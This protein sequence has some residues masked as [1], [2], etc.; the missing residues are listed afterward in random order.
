[1]KKIHLVGVVLAF[2]APTARAAVK[3][4]PVRAMHLSAF[5]TNGR[6]VSF[7][8]SEATEGLDLTGDG[9]LLAFVLHVHDVATSTTV[10]TGFDA[11]GTSVL[12]ERYLAFQSI[13]LRQ[14]FDLNGDSDLTDTVLR[15]WDTETGQIVPGVSMATAFSTTRWSGDRVAF[16]ASELREGRDLN[17]DLDALD[18]VPH[19][20]DAETGELVA[21]PVSS[22]DFRLELDSD[23]L[24]FPVDEVGSS[25]N[26]DPD[27][28]D[29]VLHVFDLSTRTV[30]NLGRAV[31]RLPSGQPWDGT[32]LVRNGLVAFRVPESAEGNTNLNGDPLL[33]TFDT[34]LHVWDHSS[35]TLRNLGLGV[36]RFLHN[37]FSS[38]IQIEGDVIAFAAD[39]FQQNDVSLNGDAELGAK[40]L[41]LFDRTT[42]TTT[43]L[44]V[45]ASGGFEI[46]GSRIAFVMSEQ[47]QGKSDA[48][49]DSDILDFVLQL[50]E[51]GSPRVNLELA[52]FAMINPQRTFLFDLD[53]DL[54]AFGVSEEAQGGSLNADAD[55]QD[56]VLHT[57]DAAAGTTTNV[58]LDTVG[59]LAV[60]DRGVAFGVNELHEG[61]DLNGNG[62]LSNIVLHLYDAVT[63]SID[64]LHAVPVVIV[65]PRTT[66]VGTF[67]YNDGLLAYPVPEG[68]ENA[69]RN[70]DGDTNDLVLFTASLDRNPATYLQ[71]LIGDVRSAGLRPAVENA[72]V[73]WLELA[74]RAVAAGNEGAAI[75]IL[76]GFIRAVDA[77]PAFLIPPET[78]D[79]FVASARVIIGLLE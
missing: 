15:V 11:S 25:L 76:E 56:V 14:G 79:E 37:D 60:S 45:D 34:V 32:F 61:A 1:M 71:N 43:N 53:G 48:N 17:G 20:F 65:N 75:A 10:S 3:V 74:A 44:V 73:A 31:T 36:D 24:A 23:L 22:F 16:V 8:V 72:L 50:V 2:L 28:T 51:I 63:G 46:D 55:L 29:A 47:H 7:L 35:S 39:E 12:G 52:L 78:A 54:L 77:A 9:M 40:V 62:D 27:A 69:D 6:S 59:R 68:A 13:E 19:V 70:G 57:H 64:P 66:F 33:D 49:G 5:D 41:H 18:F 30:T 26:T 21:V 67:V 42:A 58:G 4:D 38:P